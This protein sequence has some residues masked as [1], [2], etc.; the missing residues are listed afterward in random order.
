[1]KKYLVS[2]LLAPFLISSAIPEEYL[3]DL[4]RM[5]AFFQQDELSIA[6]QYK[7]FTQADNNLMDSKSG[8]FEK[9]GLNYYYFLDGISIIQ[10]EK[11]NVYVNDVDKLI[12]I[13]EAEVQSASSLMSF[14]EA[15]KGCEVLTRAES[16]NNYIYTLTFKKPVSDIYSGVK[17]YAKKSSFAPQKIIFEY[18]QTTSQT[19]KSGKLIK[20]KLRMEVTYSEVRSESKR[21]F[22]TSDYFKFQN[23]K[24]EATSKY[25]A[26]QL[27]DQR[28]QNLK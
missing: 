14:E 19:D 1:M 17:I 9:S 27:I 28:T 7:V 10:N 4:E 8:V 12:A 23:D 25:S 20:D 24:F 22:S 21:S 3:S 2:L 5:R 11:W 16:D 26:Y 15:T 6:L 18:A 13:K